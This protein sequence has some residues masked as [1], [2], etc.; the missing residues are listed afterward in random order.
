MAEELSDA[1][2]IGRLEDKFGLYEPILAKLHGIIS[3]PDAIDK[4]YEDLQT[5]RDSRIEMKGKLCTLIKDQD[6]IYR[7]TIKL[8][9]DKTQ[10]LE[11]EVKECP[12]KD[13]I[14]KMS[15][16]ERDVDMI[17]ILD[18]RLEIT[19]RAIESFK[20]KG[21]DLLLRIVPWVVAAGASSWA[22][23]KP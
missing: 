18:D 5:L 22:V 2:R 8:M 13:V 4:I 1:L 3:V 11:K 15:N 23:F 20:L 10:V 12:I 19:E 21:W 7:D 16:I 6:K 17:K 9:E 14:I